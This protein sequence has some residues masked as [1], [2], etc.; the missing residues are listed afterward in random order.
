MGAPPQAVLSEHFQQHMQGRR[1]HSAV[2]TTFRFEP[3]FFEAEV[4][5]VFL[6]GGFSHV[7]EVR[8]AQLED[9]LREIP[10]H[11]AV[12]YDQ[13]G[14][15]PGQRS[16]KLDIGRF[17]LRLDHAACFHPKNVLVLV[18]GAEPPHA[19]ALLCAC[20]SANL[21]EAGWWRNVEVAHV[22]VISSGDHTRL[23]K[24]LLD[25]LD[26]L[27]G[28]SRTTAPH[29]AVDAIGGFL[30]METTLALRRS[31]NQRYLTHM[32]QGTQSLPAFIGD[33]VDDTL[34]GWNLEVISP[35]FD[36]GPE[37]APV[38]ALQRRFE[39][40]AMRV[41]LPRNDAGE[42]LCGKALYRAVA[43]TKNTYWAELPK[44]FHAAQSDKAKR[45]TVHA[46]VYRFFQPVRGG[47]EIL[48]VGSANLTVAGCGAEDG[49]GRVRN[50]ESGF[51]VEVDAPRKP[52]WWL[53]VA[54]S[55]P[56]RFA[57][58]Q[59]TEGTR[60]CDE[61]RLQ[62]AHSWATQLS[63][64]FWDGPTPSPP[65]MLHGAHHQGLPLQPLPSRQW[66]ELTAADGIAIQEMLG[67]SSLIEVRVRGAAAGERVLVQ[68]E[69]MAQRPSLVLALSPA[70]ILRYWAMLTPEQRRAYTEAHALSVAGGD[71]PQAVRLLPLRQSDGLFDRYAGIF[72]A[73]HC[74]EQGLAESFG[75]AKGVA[76]A[77]RQCR[78]RDAEYRLFGCKYDSLGTLL[79]RIL[80]DFDAG[81][82]D[83]VEHYLTLLCAQQLLAQ[84]R[85]WVPQDEPRFWEDH[86]ADL[87]RIE[88]LIGRS[89]DVRKAIQG[90]DAGMQGF[91]A[92]FE[93]LF[94]TRST[95]LATEPAQ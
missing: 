93:P 13:R 7:A 4:L 32:H 15:V 52:D 38:T 18:E 19:R 50:W 11:I 9:A 69:G 27:K 73:F 89:C 33:V 48:Y 3:D 34:K 37:S 79:E 26:D 58:A 1:V 46:K 16:S 36:G 40:E 85:Q 91:L 43:Q 56:D 84:A 60:E 29:A 10:G 53:E 28:A 95:A 86:D 74:L 47:R 49:Q 12:Y 83:R 39:P 63:R 76:G 24:P 31:R 87:A 80:G 14:L 82:G 61:S 41:F 94:I 77:I 17:P 30:R 54:G 75:V 62:I 21:T 72:H 55:P 45:R 44:S 8:I 57:P 20:L 70:D 5:P 42:A 71:D 67:I 78:L 25:L 81:T 88:S 90:E 35:Y 6:D 2:F 23:R 51:L 22:E 92:W 64:V 59:E 66:T 65:L 68:E